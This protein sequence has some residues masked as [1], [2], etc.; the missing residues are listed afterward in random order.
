VVTKPFDL[1][2]V[3]CGFKVSSVTVKGRKG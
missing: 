2:H 1:D 3:R